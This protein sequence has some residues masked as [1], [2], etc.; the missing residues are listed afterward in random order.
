M[1]G[2]MVQKPFAIS[3]LALMSSTKQVFA[4]VT[5]TS[6]TLGAFP[7]KGEVGST[8]TLRVSLLGQLTS[9]GSPVGAATIHI[10][11]TGEGNEITV[12]TSEFGRYST[13]VDLAQGTHEIHAYFPGDDTHTSSSATK[14]V[15]A[16]PRSQAV[17][18]EENATL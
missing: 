9:E 1:L 2:D 13:F 11:G 10:S 5:S 15:T 6:L 3:V 4:Q 14:E 7:N 17:G 12:T 18:E 8:G 16:A